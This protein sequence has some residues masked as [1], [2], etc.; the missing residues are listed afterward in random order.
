MYTL[1]NNLLNINI[2]PIG[3]ELCAIS[4]VNN[5]NQFLWNADPNIWHSHAPNLFPVIGCLKDDRYIY[6]NKVFKMKKHGFVRKN[7]DFTLKTK[8]QT[9]ITFVL[10][11]NNLLYESYPFL[12]QFEISYTLEDNTILIN[13]RV[14]NTDKKTMYFSLGGHPA[15]TCPL[16]KDESYADYFLEFD[17]TET[18]ES[19]LLNMSNGLIS[20]KTKPVF[21]NKNKITLHKD[22]FN[23]D[24][25]I[26]KNLKSRKVTLKHKTKGP[27]LSMKFEDF[28]YLGIWAKPNAPYVCIEPWTGIAD[29]EHTNQKIEDKEGII[30]LKSNAVFNASYKIEIDKGHLG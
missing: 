2:K 1:K 21:T 24:A 8:S 10:S 30:A 28:P 15:F 14:T 6:N 16:Y 3:A 23:D 29:T 5:Y 20:D 11:S 4:S 26:F 22:L 17:K 13:H 18:E 12:F 7:K 9:N 27:V 25:L 19:Y